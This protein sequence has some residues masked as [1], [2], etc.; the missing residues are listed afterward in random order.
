MPLET[1]PR[2]LRWPISKPP[3][4]D[5]ANRSER[6]PVPDGEVVRTADDLDRFAGAGVDQDAGGSCPPP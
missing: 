5:G 1:T 4:E 6:D 2:I 3:G